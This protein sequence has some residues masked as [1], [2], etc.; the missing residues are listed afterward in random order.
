MIA[1]SDS[2]YLT[3]AIVW[4]IDLRLTNVAFLRFVFSNEPVVRL[5]G[6]RERIR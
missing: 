2:T 4:S 1:I 3:H 6:L 5:R